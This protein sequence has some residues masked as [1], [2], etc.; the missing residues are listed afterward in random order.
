VS[1]LLIHGFPHRGALWDPVRAELSVLEGGQSWSVLAPDL[2]GFGDAPAAASPSID[3]YADDLLALLDARGVARAVVCG[4]SMGGYVALALWRRH[5]TRV[6]ALVLA[7]T[8][9]G[10]DDAAQRARRVELAAR[11]RAEG[12]EAV[13]EAQLSG[14]VGKT[15]RARHPERAESL[16]VLM[17]SVPVGGI[18]AALDAMRER[19]DATP[20]LAGIT[21]PTLVVVGDEDVLTPPREARALA[22]AVPGARLVEIPDA[23]HV[24]CW[25]RPDAFAAALADFLAALPA[26]SP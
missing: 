5:P 7:D 15:T 23:G 18:V 3:A 17:A 9:A 1:L 25:E 19:P 4:L 6:R 11:A 14:A 13:A 8:R 20:L 24:S 2:R 21:V 22:A 26:E 12:S 16:R 10:A